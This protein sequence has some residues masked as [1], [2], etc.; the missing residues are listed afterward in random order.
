MV[1]TG[2]HV[3]LDH[4]LIPLLQSSGINASDLINSLLTSYFHQDDF[5]N[6]PPKALHI[7]LK[8]YDLRKAMQKLREE[9]Q[10][11]IYEDGMTGSDVALQGQGVIFVDGGKKHD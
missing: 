6:L 11:V 1:K 7:A 9:L 3:T 10:N 5:D 8:I 2:K 4:Q